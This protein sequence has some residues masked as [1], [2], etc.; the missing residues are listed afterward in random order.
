MSLET[1]LKWA[2]TG[3]SLL[4]TMI[5]GASAY[6]IQFLTGVNFG[7]FSEIAAVLLAFLANFIKVWTAKNV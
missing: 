3:K 1:K 7:A 4:I 2:K 5:G 6:G